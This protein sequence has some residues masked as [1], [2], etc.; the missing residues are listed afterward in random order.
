M[1][2]E[3][4][5]LEA[6]Q[7]LLSALAKR[8]I[9]RALVCEKSAGELHKVACFA[10]WQ[11]WQ[12]APRNGR[13]H[14]RNPRRP[15]FC[16]CCGVLK[17]SYDVY[18]AHKY[19]QRRRGNVMSAYVNG[20]TWMSC[21]SLSLMSR[22][23]QKLTSD[24]LELGWYV[25]MV[26]DKI[27]PRHLSQQELPMKPGP[28]PSKARPPWL[29]EMYFGVVKSKTHDWNWEEAVAPFDRCFVVVIVTKLN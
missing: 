5:I 3:V 4:P 24:L 28:W 26:L 2:V 25:W 23:C 16:H 14:W 21:V 12:K 19:F 29:D 10:L 15:K 18:P 8:V 22:W 7:I 6:L 11:Y 17:F 20:V 1:N 27:L 9:R 13:I